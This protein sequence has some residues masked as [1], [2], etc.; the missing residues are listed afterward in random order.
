MF[1]PTRYKLVS[2]RGEGKTPLT[3]FDAALFGAGVGNYNLLKV[4]SILPPA[5]KERDNIDVPPGGLLPIAYST[6]TGTTP[7]QQ[8]AAAVAAGVVEDGPGVIMEF[9]GFCSEDEAVRTVRDMVVEAVSLRGASLVE[10]KTASAA[11]TVRTIGSVFAG[12]ALW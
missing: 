3:A 2:A 6:L 9:H 11:M 10:I 5:A 7:G 4:S 8:L 1:V 12:V